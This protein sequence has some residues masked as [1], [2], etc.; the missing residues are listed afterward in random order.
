MTKSLMDYIKDSEKAG[1]AYT[2]QLS[3]E[4]FKKLE[5]LRK[6]NYYEPLTAAEVVEDLIIKA[7]NEYG[8]IMEGL[9]GE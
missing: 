7:F 4:T 8:E 9:K 5:F 2:V 6:Y 1:T 3:K